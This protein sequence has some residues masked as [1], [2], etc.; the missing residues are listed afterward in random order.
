MSVVTDANQKMAAN[1]R[2]SDVA[3]AFQGFSC[4][5]NKGNAILVRQVGNYIAILVGLDPE[6]QLVPLMDSIS[7]KIEN[8]RQD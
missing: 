6:I 1:K 4:R 2:F 8:E 7:S 3:M 5:D